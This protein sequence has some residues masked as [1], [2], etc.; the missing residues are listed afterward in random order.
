MSDEGIALAYDDVTFRY[1]GSHG[2]VLSGVSMAVPAGAFALL[3]GGTGSG[4]S[5]L[6]SLAKPQI[7]PAGDR[8]ARCACSADPWMTW[9]GPRH[10]RSAMCSKTPITRSCATA[11]GTRWHSAW[12]TSGTPQG[13]MAPSCCRGELLLWHGAVVPQRYRCSFGR[14]QAAAGA[15]LDA[16]HATARAAARRADG[17]ARPHRGAQFPACLIPREPGVG[18]HRGCCDA[19]A[20]S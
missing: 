10:V 4:K 15:C 3:V 9:M 19:R 7:A 2:D 6:L 5:T 18:M 8:A 13:E 20:P 17:A 16:R 14:S 11:C 12:K 1:P